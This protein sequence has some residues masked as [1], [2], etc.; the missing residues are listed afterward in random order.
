MHKTA[1]VADHNQIDFIALSAVLKVRY[2]SAFMLCYG[3]LK[4][5]RQLS[6]SQ[7]FLSSADFE[8]TIS[9]VDNSVV[10]VFVKLC[11]LAHWTNNTVICLAA[12]Q[13]SFFEILILL[14]QHLALDLFIQIN[15]LVNCDQIF[16]G[17][18]KT[19]FLKLFVEKISQF[20]L[21]ST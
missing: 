7:F 14:V 10:I 9:A 16:I 20:F 17:F 2:L 19:Y 15:R 12:Q 8:T 5:E 11:P 6:Q 4:L 1:F 18:Q 13:P 21:F 3:V